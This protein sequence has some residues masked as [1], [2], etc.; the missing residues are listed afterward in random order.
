[1][2]FDIKTI[3]G[4]EKIS[5]KMFFKIKYNYRMYIRAYAHEKGIIFIPGM[6]CEIFL[7]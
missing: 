5:S 4:H 3:I 2:F 6:I 7:M 1:M